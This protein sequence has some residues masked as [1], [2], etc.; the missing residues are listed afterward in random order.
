MNNPDPKE[1]L[2]VTI[3]KEIYLKA[4]EEVKR[5]KIPLSRLI[6]NFLKFFADPEV[7]CFKC[8]EKFFVKKAKICPKCG[9]LICPQ[10]GACR[11]SLSEE[12][13]IAVFYMRKLYEELL[14]GRI[15]D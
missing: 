14:A 11:C 13:A 3:E 2:T 6:E 10:C 5:K 12:T 8:G 15:G 7:Y 4:K 1:R 9:W